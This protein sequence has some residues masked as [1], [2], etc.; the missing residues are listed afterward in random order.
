MGGDKKFH[1]TLTHFILYNVP[2]C[3]GHQI[4]D[5]TF[6]SLSGADFLSK[7]WDLLSSAQGEFIWKKI[8]GNLKFH[9]TLLIFFFL[10]EVTWCPGQNIYFEHL[11]S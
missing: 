2:W 5:K 10:C 1:P 8:G 4:L 6:I 11:N 3:P 7:I 9:L